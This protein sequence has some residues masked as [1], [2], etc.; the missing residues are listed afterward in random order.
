MCTSFIGLGYFVNCGISCFY[1]PLFPRHC[2]AAKVP[3]V[4]FR[5]LH[6]ITTLHT[7]R[8]LQL[9]YQPG[10]TS[11]T[12]QRLFYHTDKSSTQYS[13]FKRFQR[14]APRTSQ[15]TYRLSTTHTIIHTL[16][17]T[18]TFPHRYHFGYLVPNHDR[19][20]LFIALHYITFL[21]GVLVLVHTCV[22]VQIMRAYLF[23]C[24]FRSFEN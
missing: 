21:G 11:A 6:L 5:L 13:F 15:S 9:Q 18:T 24:A 19:H 17:I 23:V 4:H 2:I 7:T 22:S 20:L 3:F 16:H 12:T 10:S 1:A 14:V 8:L